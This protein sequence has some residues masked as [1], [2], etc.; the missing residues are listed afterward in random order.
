[1]FS[2]SFAVLGTFGFLG[3]VLAAL[4]ALVVSACYYV[5]GVDCRCGLTVLASF[6]CR[7]L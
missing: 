1:M 4:V 5:G 6:G 2:C 7:G 3:L